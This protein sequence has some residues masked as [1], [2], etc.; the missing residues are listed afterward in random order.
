MPP[1]E[2]KST[3]EKQEEIKTPEATAEAP[4]TAESIQAQILAMQAKLEE[5]KKTSQNAEQTET[6]RVDKT[7]EKL[8]VGNPDETVAIKA[9]VKGIEVDKQAVLTTA[10]TK[11]GEETKM[12]ETPAEKNDVIIEDK[13]ELTSEQK[14]EKKAQ[15]YEK[16]FIEGDKIAQERQKANKKG[17]GATHDSLSDQSVNERSFCAQK[18]AE[19]YAEAGNM[20]KAREMWDKSAETTGE[21]SELVSIYEQSHSKIAKEKL[22][23]RT[24]ELEKQGQEFMTAD[25][26]EKIGFK[27]DAKRLYNKVTELAYKDKSYLEAAAVASERL[28]RE[29]QAKK[30]YKEYADG[31][32]KSQTPESSFL[33]KDAAEAYEKAGKEDSAKV[34]WEKYADKLV[35]DE[36]LKQTFH[37]YSDI[38]KAYEKAGNKIKAE[39][40]LAKSK[41]RR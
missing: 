33:F 30:L 35:S 2:I 22:I 24:Q 1:E 27:D 18:A 3:N 14:N 29:D 28:G 10:E 12:T 41:E 11:I 6:A 16:R 32:W 15:E 40:M 13:N 34:C 36:G 20:I 4:L 7:V 39:E 17:E 8:S 21:T 5:M 37:Y 9:E 23:A 38:A 26:F 19:S 31:L 25:I